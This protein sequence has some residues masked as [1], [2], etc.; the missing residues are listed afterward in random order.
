MFAPTNG[1]SH[2]C[3]ARRSALSVRQRLPPPA[4]VPA[5]PCSGP[6]LLA[7]LLTLFDPN[8]SLPAEA[9]T[10]ALEL[11]AKAGIDITPVLKDILVSLKSPSPLL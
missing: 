6:P 10:A 2:C 1:S 3:F 4:A 11:A 7:F 5:P 9:F 8:P